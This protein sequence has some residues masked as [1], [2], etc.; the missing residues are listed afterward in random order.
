M[1]RA[2]EHWMELQQIKDDTKLAEILGIT[3]DE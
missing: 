1:G 2:K 3:Y